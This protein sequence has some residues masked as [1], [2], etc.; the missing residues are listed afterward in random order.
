[1]KNQNKPIAVFLSQVWKI[2]L[3]VMMS[4]TNGCY[5]YNVHAPNYDPSTEYKKK[6]AHSLFWGL[7]QK[8]VSAENC[9]V[10]HDCRVEMCK[11]LPA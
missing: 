10:T 1:M 9:T 3:I 8:D 2:G 7:A 5:H 11:A 6:T 4:I